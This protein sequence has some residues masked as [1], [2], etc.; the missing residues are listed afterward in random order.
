MKRLLAYMI[1]VPA[2]FGE[3][4]FAGMVWLFFGFG[5]GIVVIALFWLYQTKKMDLLNIKTAKSFLRNM[6]DKKP[7]IYADEGELPIYDRTKVKDDF[8]V[9]YVV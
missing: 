3:L 4:I 9:K 5:L 6:D 1:L 8:R 7:K 2:L